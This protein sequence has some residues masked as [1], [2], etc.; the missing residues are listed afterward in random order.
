MAWKIRPTETLKLESIRILDGK[1]VSLSNGSKER[2]MALM[3]VRLSDSSD[4]S[5]LDYAATMRITLQQ[6]RMRGLFDGLYRA[7]VPFLYISMMTPAQEEEEEKELFEFDLVVGT[8]V[9]T[10]SKELGEAAQ[11]LEQRASVLAATLTVALPSATVRRLCRNELRD[12]VKTLFLPSEPR[13]PQVGS[14]SVVSTL[15]SFE[16]RSPSVGSLGQSPQFYLPNAAE[17]GKTGILLGT[18]KSAGGEFHDFHLQLDDL[19]R[20]VAILGM[21]GSGKSTTA[22]TVVQQVAEMGLPV[23]VLDWHNEYA[24][25]VSRVGGQVLSPGKDD[26]SINPVE[27][28]QSTD[29]MEHIAMVTDIFSDIYH[30]THPQAYM[31]RNALQKR[32]T[33]SS[34]DEIP[35]LASLVRT[36]EAYP[37]RSAYDNETKVAL[38]RRLVPLTQGQAGKAL[39]GPGT[40]SLEELLGKVVCIELGHLRDAQTRSVFTDIMLKMVYEYRIRRRSSLEHLTVVE[41]ARNV[42]PSRRTEDPPSVGERMISELRKF[43][44]AMLFVAQFPTQVASEMIKNSGVRVIHRVAWPEDL[45]LIGDA[46]SLTREQ[47]DHIGAL[48][49]GEAVVS[50]SRMQKPILVQV[51][52]DSV[53]SSESKDLSFTAEP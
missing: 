46:L 38:L 10:K 27:A 37:L 13:L 11:S 52:A 23:M 26:F 15:E 18:V 25:I 42:A 21:T 4:E 3:R 2:V 41:E 30:F 1:F 43:G 5:R 9:D 51:R 34:E 24:P 44:E 36:I 50:L 28:S 7:G 8:W 19:K 49:V 32:V 40:Y 39:D 29:P 35:S 47:K 6:Q 22:A 12:F 17:S 53:L 33:E 48:Q 16:G 14:A 45:A 31:F 20:H